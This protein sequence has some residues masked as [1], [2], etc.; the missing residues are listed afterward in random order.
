MKTD[1]VNMGLVLRSAIVRPMFAFLGV[2]RATAVDQPDNIISIIHILRFQVLGFVARAAT[3]G[4]ELE[5]VAALTQ[6][7]DREGC[8]FGQA[9]AADHIFFLG[10]LEATIATVITMLFR[11]IDGLDEG[12]AFILDPDPFTAA[13]S[14]LTEIHFV[15][16]G[17][18]R[19]GA[20][21][22]SG[23]EQFRCV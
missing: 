5:F 12:G 19:G 18:E 16:L 3:G 14:I 7:I 6:D 21:D 13:L 15:G 17:A 8:A 9:P 20:N 2:E 4:F 10:Q 22:N 23:E 1:R 11:N